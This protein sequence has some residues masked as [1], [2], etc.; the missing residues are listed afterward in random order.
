MNIADELI[1]FN[2]FG[3]LNNSQQIRYIILGAKKMNNAPF[4]YLRP[5]TPSEAC[6]LKAKHGKEAVLWAGGTD[7]VPQLQEGF[8][9]PNY[10]IDMSFIPDFDYIRCDRENICIGSLTRVATLEESTDITHLIPVISEAAN[11]LGSPQIRNMATI[12]GNLC[13]ASPCADL[14]VSLLVLGAELKLLSMAGERWVALE[15]FYRGE[16]IQED[17]FQA[18]KPTVLK[19]NELL[20]EIRIPVPPSETQF[21]FFKLRR[22]AVDIAI[23]NVAVRITV[24]GDGIVSDVK[25]ALGSVAPT[26]MRSKDTENMLLGVNISKIDSVMLEKASRK[27]AEETRPITDIRGSAEYRRIISEVMV[28]QGIEKVMQKLGVRKI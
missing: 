13:N 22:T 10:C 18:G 24:D 11:H 12:G 27:A 1:G 23:V 9:A 2:Y 17:I 21:A 6:S 15:D 26:P 16:V 5:T 7:L 4:K 20:G 19:E 14:A 8:V 28:R 25:I 3:L